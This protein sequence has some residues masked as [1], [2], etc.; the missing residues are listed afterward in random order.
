[1]GFSSTPEP[2]LCFDFQYMLI[3]FGDMGYFVFVTDS[4]LVLSALLRFFFSCLLSFSLALKEIW[5]LKEFINFPTDRLKF[6]WECLD[7]VLAKKA[8]LTC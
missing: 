2:R 1:M 3:T 7:S 5:E 6:L 8:R 4:S